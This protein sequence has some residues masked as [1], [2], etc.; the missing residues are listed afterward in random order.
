METPINIDRFLDA[1]GKIT[2]MPHKQKPRQALLLYLAAKFEPNVIY[3]ERQVNDICNC[4]HTFGDFFLLRRELVDYGLLAR[5]RDGSQYWR[6]ADP[7]C[8][9]TPLPA[10]PEE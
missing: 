10:A 2:Q 5:K 8:D 9:E 4:W 1:E 7:P 6:V 3:T